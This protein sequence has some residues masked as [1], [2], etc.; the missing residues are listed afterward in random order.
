MHDDASSE[1]PERTRA[2]GLAAD[3]WD[4]VLDARLLTP[5]S[6]RAID[7]D[8]VVFVSS[9]GVAAAVARR[10]PHLDWDLAEAAV[11][12]DELVCP[13][14]GW[15]FTT[16]GRARK[17]NLAGRTDDKGTICRWET[18]VVDGWLEIAR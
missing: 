1:A 14:H 3:G 2:R 17:R 12:G 4:R 16:E 5:S 15:S 6:C 11:A 10:C 18:R 9:T 7:E 13:G 8:T